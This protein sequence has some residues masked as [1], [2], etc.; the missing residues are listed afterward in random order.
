MEIRTS[1]EPLEGHGQE[2]K[3][4]RFEANMHSQR[5]REALCLNQ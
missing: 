4:N 1:E 2:M 5:P 3:I